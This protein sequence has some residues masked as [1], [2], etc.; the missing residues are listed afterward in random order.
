MTYVLIAAAFVAG[1]AWLLHLEDKTLQRLIDHERR[2]G[3]S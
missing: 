1:V 3:T 2:H